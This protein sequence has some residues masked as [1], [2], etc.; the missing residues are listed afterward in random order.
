MECEGCVCNYLD[1]RVGEA[2]LSLEQLY[3]SIMIDLGRLCVSRKV[4]LICSPH[5]SW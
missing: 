5:P 2:H 3:L 1:L 4:L